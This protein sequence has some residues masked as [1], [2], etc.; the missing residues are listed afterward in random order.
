MEISDFEKA[1]KNCIGISSLE[2][3]LL[4]YRY[5]TIK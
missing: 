2:N 5:L 1:E 3:I 4:P